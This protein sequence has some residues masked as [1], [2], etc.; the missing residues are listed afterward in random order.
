VGREAIT[1]HRHI[2]PRG[3]ERVLLTLAE[4]LMAAGDTEAAK[5]TLREAVDELSAREAAIGDPTYRR[6][7]VER[8]P[9]NVRIR[10]LAGTWLGGPS[11]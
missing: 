11:Q 8:V 4:A 2:G 7:F 9:G 10:R 3:V 5:V 6:H 1:L